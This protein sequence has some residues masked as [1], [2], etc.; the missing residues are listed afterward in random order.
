MLWFVWVAVDLRARNCKRGDDPH[1]YQSYAQSA[2]N[3]LKRLCWLRIVGGSL[4][5]KRSRPSPEPASLLT[6][7]VMYRLTEVQWAKHLRNRPISSEVD[8]HSLTRACTHR[9]IG[10]SRILKASLVLHNRHGMSA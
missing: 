7:L 3:C 1:T 2:H 8:T 4:T 5:L 9:S 6:E 10:M